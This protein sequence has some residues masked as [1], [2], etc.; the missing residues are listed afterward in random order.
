[1]LVMKS[2][3]YSISSIKLPGR[4]F[5]QRILEGPFLEGCAYKEDEFY[6]HVCILPKTITKSTSTSLPSSFNVYGVASSTFV[7]MLFLQGYSS[8]LSTFL[9]PQGYIY[10]KEWIGSS[11]ITGN[12]QTKTTE[13]FNDNFF[14]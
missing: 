2:Q 7:S 12:T 11:S 3:K 4:L 8:L 10:L 6:F 5:K 9:C 1:M 13:R 14:I